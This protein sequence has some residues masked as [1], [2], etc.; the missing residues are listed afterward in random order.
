L[1]KYVTKNKSHEPGQVTVLKENVLLVRPE[2]P[3][4]CEMVQDE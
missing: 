1:K 2:I 4:D 3:K